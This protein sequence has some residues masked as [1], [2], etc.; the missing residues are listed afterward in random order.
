[1]KMKQRLH[2][3]PPISFNF[4]TGFEWVFHLE[5]QLNNFYSAYAFN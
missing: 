2:E 3:A 4:L 1:M 5:L